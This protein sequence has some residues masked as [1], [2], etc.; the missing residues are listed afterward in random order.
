MP[1]TDLLEAIQRYLDGDYALPDTEP[2]KVPSVSDIEARILGQLLLVPG[3]YGCGLVRATDNYVKRGTVYVT[4]GR[5]EDKGLVVSEE[6]TVAE[7]MQKLRRYRTTPLGER[8]YRARRIARLAEQMAIGE[9][10]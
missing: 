4:L 2:A 3:S 8:L 6:G 10:T 1:N 7:T 5:M 9:A